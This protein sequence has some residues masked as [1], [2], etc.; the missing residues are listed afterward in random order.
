MKWA[1]WL[2]A[3]ALVAQVAWMIHKDMILQTDCNSDTE[4]QSESAAALANKLAVPDDWRAS[5]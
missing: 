3:L 1:L 4:Q 5:I 2:I